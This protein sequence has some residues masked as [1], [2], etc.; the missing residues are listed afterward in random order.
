MTYFIDLFSKFWTFL[1]PITNLLGSF[2]PTWAQ[3]FLY[4][5]LIIFPTVLTYKK[6]KKKQKYVPKKQINKKI[7]KSIKESYK[8]L[9]NENKNILGQR[10]RVS[11]SLFK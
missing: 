7:K 3:I 8:Y 5:L 9:L 11:P 1:E 4:C 2:M 10:L 6:V